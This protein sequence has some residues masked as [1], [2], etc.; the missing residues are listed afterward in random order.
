MKSKIEKDNYQRIFFLVEKRLFYNKFL[1]HKITYNNMN[2]FFLKKKN[3]SSIRNTCLFSKK[4][5]SISSFFKCSRI[6]FRQFALQGFFC[7]LIKKSW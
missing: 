4:S 1:K 7:G 3:F 6:T 5:R 2:F